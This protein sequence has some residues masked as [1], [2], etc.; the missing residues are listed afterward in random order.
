MRIPFL[1]LLLKTFILK[2]SLSFKLDY[3]SIKVHHQDHVTNKVE[4]SYIS[5]LYPRLHYIFRFGLQ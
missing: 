1:A 5:F 4:R 3:E 2:Q